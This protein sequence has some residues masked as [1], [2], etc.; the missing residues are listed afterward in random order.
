MKTG[1]LIT[2][3]NQ[4]IHLLLIDGSYIRA[5]WS[6]DLITCCIFGAWGVQYIPN[7]QLANLDSIIRRHRLRSWLAT[8]FRGH[9]ALHFER[10]SRQFVGSKGS[11]TLRDCEKGRFP[12]DAM[13]RVLNTVVHTMAHVRTHT[14]I[15]ARTP[16]DTSRTPTS[17]ITRPQLQY[18]RN[19]YTVASLYRSRQCKLPGRWYL[20]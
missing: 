14:H 2:K 10:N 20:R 9:R 7:S 15:R 19:R 3:I 8:I 13:A 1:I 6:I 4:N 12:A 11:C 16:S 5:I 17:S 18:P